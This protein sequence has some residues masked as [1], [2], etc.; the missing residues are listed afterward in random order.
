VLGRR[1]GFRGGAPSFF[2]FSQQ[3]AAMNKVVTVT[4]SVRVETVFG[5]GVRVVGEAPWLGQWT[6]EKGLA[7][8]YGKDFEWTG[9]ASL[10][11]ADVL[12]TKVPI[13]FKFIVQE[14]NGGFRCALQRSAIE[15]FL[16]PFPPRAAFPP[17]PSPFRPPLAFSSFSLIYINLYFSWEA[18]NNRALQALSTSLV[19]R[20]SFG[21]TSS[22]AIELLASPVPPSPS[23]SLLL[24]SNYCC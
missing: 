1:L 9:A 13:E 5:E 24:H 7:L 14:L 16:P 6:A 17:R 18:G 3:Q 12:A 19:Y 20:S 11:E 23:L 2:L 15:I 4:F 8:T 21:D 10:K 22:G